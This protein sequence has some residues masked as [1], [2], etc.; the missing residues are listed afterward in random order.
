MQRHRSA[1][2]TFRSASTVPATPSA[3]SAATAATPVRS[4]PHGPCIDNAVVH[5]STYGVTDL[6]LSSLLDFFNL[7]VVAYMLSARC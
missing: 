7:F 2:A 3:S 1:R 6:A 5:I 4:K